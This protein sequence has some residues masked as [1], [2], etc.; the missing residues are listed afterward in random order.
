MKFARITFLIAGIYGV[1]VLTPLFF[2]EPS[3][4]S[5]PM[6]H[7][8]YYYGF[9][10]IALAWQVAFLIVSRD[11]ARYVALFP[12]TWLEKFGFVVACAILHTQDRISQSML[13]A[14]ALDMVLG[15]LFVIS[16]FKLRNQ[17]LTTSD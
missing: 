6:T 16:Y 11:P 13:I 14:A 7:P 15:I 2:K 4:G 8:V 17:P 9:L 5:S 12:A 10:C 1:L 3:I